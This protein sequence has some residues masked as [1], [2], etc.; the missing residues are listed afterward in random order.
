MKKPHVDFLLDFPKSQLAILARAQ[1]R[2]VRQRKATGVNDEQGVLNLAR[3]R[4]LQR[5][6]RAVELGPVELIALVEWELRD[7]PRA[8][9]NARREY[10][11]FCH[12]LY[13]RLT[14]ARR[15]G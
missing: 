10:I 9:G 14:R 11:A 13:R 4:S 5:K 1:E 12:R 2:L 8:L 3:L 6:D 15:K 7:R